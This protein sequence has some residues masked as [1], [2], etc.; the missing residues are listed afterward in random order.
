MK[1]QTRHIRSTITERII[2]AVLKNVKEEPTY[3]NSAPYAAIVALCEKVMTNL[4]FR[5]VCCQ[6]DIMHLTYYIPSP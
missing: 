5:D 2:G 3:V 1:P 4:V 6:P